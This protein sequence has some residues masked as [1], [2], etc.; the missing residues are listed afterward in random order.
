[1][2]IAYIGVGFVLIL[3]CLLFL[4]QLERKL[5]R[6]DLVGIITYLI[7]IL[8]FMATAV[9]FIITGATIW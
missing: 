2:L 3:F 4:H 1:M 6:K 8:I 5:N 9:L 7:L